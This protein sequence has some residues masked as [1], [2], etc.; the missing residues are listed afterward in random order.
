MNR[1]KTLGRSLV[2][3]ALLA[4]VYGA[5]VVLVSDQY[6]QLMLTLVAV[7]AIMGISWNVLSGYSGLVSF[8]HAAFFGLGAYTVALG[9][10]HFS[11]S[12]W[13]TIPAAGLVGA[14]AG[15][16]VGLPTFRL[17][18]H[19][20]AL[21]MLAY[22]LALLYVF[23]WLGYQEV[24]MPMRREA[25]ALYMQFADAR[26][27]SMIA[28]LL[29]V[30]A[31]V[32]SLLIET[33]RFGMALIAIKQNE[34]AAEGAGIE[35]RKWKLR[36]IAISG[37]IAGMVG[38]FYAVVLIVV[39]PPSVFGMLTSAQALIVALFGGIGT[40][41]GPVIGAAF[42]I[43]LSETLHAELGNVLPGIQ[44]VV[45]GVAIV[46]V[47]LLAPEGIF[48]RIRDMLQA[49][50][51]TVEPA[52][53]EPAPADRP[54]PDNVVPIPAGGRD[55][56][57]GGAG[58]GGRVML[59]VR[60]VSKNFGGLRA[61]REVSFTVPE[62]AVIGIIGPNG[63]GKTTL[64]NCLNGFQI[65]S[66]GEVLFEGQNLV[67]LPPSAV[68]RK[69]IGRTFQ[70]ARPFTRLSVLENVLVGAYAGAAD[71]A[72]AERNAREALTLV[73]LGGSADR[74]AGGLANKEQRLMELA[75][76]LAGKPKL[77]LLDETLAGLGAA[78]VEDMV[79][80]I[81]RL[82]RTGLTIVIIEHTMQAMVRLAD[83]FIVLD[84]GA[85]L[86][87][88]RP[89]DVTRDPAVIEAYLGKRWRERA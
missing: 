48:W 26:V 14:A 62:G 42:L 27:L 74:I 50:K 29:L 34:L 25:P 46:G 9:S 13:L 66:A 12:P 75:R 71:D 58:T 59:E 80:V 1:R 18:G 54:M 17:R 88:G 44:G 68:C 7:W 70:V 72:T 16:L 20:F 57:S 40:V 76:A 51:A 38:G 39:T 52:P 64:F 87:E 61:V 65:P 82:S 11:L 84:H 89:Q 23:E 77:L 10:V 32:A 19:Y 22:P 30:A 47:I 86:A 67:G 73:G 8:G 36:A 78:E 69:G 21:A 60:G 37:G 55:G 33:S 81:R 63:A 85:L 49:R 6:Y 5:A 43:P 79:N 53:A 35:T 24:A 2:V 45:F 4:A 41:W 31:I 83:R 15:I 3:L 28:G 56:A